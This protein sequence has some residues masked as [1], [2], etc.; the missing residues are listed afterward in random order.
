VIFDWF[1]VAFVIVNCNL[2]NCQMMKH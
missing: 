1:T 2:S